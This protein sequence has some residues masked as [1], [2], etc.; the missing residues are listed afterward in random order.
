[1]LYHLKIGS[2]L[3]MTSGTKRRMSRRN[4]SVARKISILCYGDS[5][6][7]KTTQFRYLSKYVWDTY[8]MR[9]RFICYDGGSLWETVADY[10]E[11]GFVDVLQVPN[12]PEYNPFAVT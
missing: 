3:S 9:S 10:V 11:E 2:K 5:G 6:S 8:K 1:M 4:F 12:A 7:G